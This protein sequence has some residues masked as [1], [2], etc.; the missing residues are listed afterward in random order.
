MW[1]FQLEQLGRRRMAGPHL[2]MENPTRRTRRR[3]RGSRDGR[4]A[5]VAMARWVYRCHGRRRA[6]A[7]LPNRQRARVRRRRSPCLRFSAVSQ[8]ARRTARQRPLLPFLRPS[9]TRDSATVLARGKARVRAKDEGINGNAK[10]TVKASFRSRAHCPLSLLNDVMI[11]QDL[12]FIRH[13][14]TR[15]SL[16]PPLLPLGVVANPNRQRIRIWIPLAGT[17]FEGQRRLSVAGQV[18]MDRETKGQARYWKGCK[19]RAKVVGRTGEGGERK[20][21]SIRRVLYTGRQGG[22]CCLE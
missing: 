5:G 4:G 16:L 15:A 1:M 10:Q 20:G 19:H 21:L 12:L 22:L 13:R 11:R 7:R 18:R 3:G 2:R 14:R 6:S 8:V 17:A 9:A